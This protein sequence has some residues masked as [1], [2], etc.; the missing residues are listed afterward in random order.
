[1]LNDQLVISDV[2]GPFRE[3]ASRCFLMTIRFNGNLGGDPCRTSE[4]RAGGRVGVCEGDV[5]GNHRREPG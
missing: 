1:M 5:A 2:T 3:P 4:N